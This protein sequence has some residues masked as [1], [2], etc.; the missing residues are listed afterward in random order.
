MVEKTLE[1]NTDN[2]V[3]EVKDLCVTYGAVQAVRN[4]GFSVESGQMVVIWS[5]RQAMCSKN[6]RQTAEAIKK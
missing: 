1:K 6:T 5:A 3:L 2:K 4:A